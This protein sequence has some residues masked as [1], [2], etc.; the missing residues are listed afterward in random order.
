MGELGTGDDTVGHPD[1]A[2][3]GRL[4]SAGSFSEC[5]SAVYHQ[6]CATEGNWRRLRRVI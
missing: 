3:P 1:S 4:R 6:I 5:V 2:R